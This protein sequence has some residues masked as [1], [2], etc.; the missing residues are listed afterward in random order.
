MKNLIRAILFGRT[1]TWLAIS[2]RLAAATMVIAIIVFFGVRQGFEKIEKIRDNPFIGHSDE[3]S[4]AL[5]AQSILRGQGIRVNYITYFFHAYPRE[6]THREDN[7]PPFMAYAIA[8]CFYIWGAEEGGGAWV[9]RLPGIFIASVG[10]PLMAALLTWSL[11]RRGY[12][13]LTAGLIMM[14]APQVYGQS[15][16]VLADGATAMLIAGFCAWMILAGGGG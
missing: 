14:S 4:Y 7:W 9:A 5:Q 10:L 16:R 15:M 12:A 1:G 13:A 11:C 6:I 2:L 8:P 3:A